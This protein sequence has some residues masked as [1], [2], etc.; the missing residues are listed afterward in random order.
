MVLTLPQ[1]TQSCEAR[2]VLLAGCRVSGKRLVWRVL[3]GQLRGQFFGLVFAGCTMTDRLARGSRRN[4]RH[5]RNEAVS[6]DPASRAL[7]TDSVSCV[8]ALGLS[9]NSDYS[10]IPPYIDELFRHG[11]GWYRGHFRRIGSLFTVFTGA[12]P[13][14]RPLSEERDGESLPVTPKDTLAVGLKRLAA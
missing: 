8:L 11:N 1:V 5:S 13:H 14:S 10:H 9:Q 6:T 4:V 7:L 3:F 12:E 2:R